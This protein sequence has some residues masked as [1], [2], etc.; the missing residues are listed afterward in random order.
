MAEISPKFLIAIAVAAIVIFSGLTFYHTDY[1]AKPYEQITLPT[2]FGNEVKMMAFSPFGSS[3]SPIE[4][5]TVNIYGY[6]H[7]SNGNPLSNFNLS[8]YVFPW[9]VHYVTGINGFY[10]V[11]LLK[12]GTFTVGYIGPGYSSS[13]NTF[14]VLSGNT[15][16]ENVTLKRASFYQVSGRTVNITQSPVDSVKLYL[17]TFFS[18]NVTSSS[19]SSNFSIFLQD[20]TYAALTLKKNYDIKP[21]PL[22]FNVTGSSVNNLILVMNHTSNISYNVYGYVRDKLN[23]PISNAYIMSLNDL[24]SIDSLKVTTNASGFYNITVPAGFNRITAGAEY[25]QS[26][27]SSLMNIQHDVM[28]NFSMTAYDP[29]TVTHNGPT[30]VS[31]L[32][33]FMQGGAQSYLKGNLSYIDYNQS[34]PY[35]MFNMQAF[36]RF[37]NSTLGDQFMK[38]MV[39]A[40]AVDVLGTIFYEPI[41]FSEVNGTARVPSYFNSKYKMVIYVNGFD[42]VRGT[43]N[44]PVPKNNTISIEL[45]PQ[46]GEVY[47]L[48][49]N[50]TGSNYSFYKGGNLVSPLLQYP[51]FT[52]YENGLVVNTSYLSNYYSLINGKVQ[53]KRTF[54]YFIDNQQNY[55]EN[56]TLNTTEVGFQGKNYTFSVS[57]KDPRNMTANITMNAS[58]SM[59]YNLT[60]LKFNTAPGVNSTYLGG[61]N[62]KGGVLNDTGTSNNNNT[63]KG[64]FSLDLLLNHVFSSNISEPFAIYVREDGYVYSGITHSVDSVITLKTNFT[65]F[66]GTGLSLYVISQN[67]TGSISSIPDSSSSS[68]SIELHIRDVADVSISTMNSMNFTFDQ[69]VKESNLLPTSTTPGM[70]TVGGYSLP[71]NYQ[72]YSYTSSST[73]YYYHLPVNQS[74]TDR[75]T[76]SDRLGGFINNTSSFQTYKNSDRN[77]FLNISSYGSILN[78]STTINLTGFV[79]QGT[80]QA[81]NFIVKES[82]ARQFYIT[83]LSNISVYGDTGYYELINGTQEIN[84]KAFFI[85]SESPLAMEYINITPEI[86][87]FRLNSYSNALIANTS[88]FIYS[89]KA[90]LENLSFFNTTVVNGQ[91][92]MNVPYAVASGST[93]NIGTRL[94]TFTKTESVIQ[95][96]QYPYAGGTIDISLK[97]IS[98]T[99]ETLIVLAGYLVPSN[100]VYSRGE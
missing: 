81:N 59:G 93:I 3:G 30:G 73:D 12:Y 39:G 80:I 72:K 79:E 91:I 89:G 25:F 20:G 49:E 65:G 52:L 98:G 35:D 32:P 15:L 88:A 34:N 53:L 5:A 64:I 94:Y 76:S 67:Y 8:V 28:Y 46:P 10:H 90:F 33:S 11:V 48:S 26:N 82:A 2:Y 77:L 19:A 55:V 18:T 56:F 16:W 45:T 42:L 95:G 69:V 9:V 57:S 83:Y 7:N 36:N 68:I 51:N 60:R 97:I 27:N 38:P 62:F 100:N 31:F 58:N 17:L 13:F 61:I 24:G 41:K 40:V 86:S 84:T 23:Q 92:E 43:Y 75:I 63:G 44:T 50:V 87:S 21:K 47:S 1:R 70:L 74:Y 22:F 85:N 99:P 66:N 6:V 54:Y 71:L 14:T 29:F 37:Y 4:N 78:I 96:L